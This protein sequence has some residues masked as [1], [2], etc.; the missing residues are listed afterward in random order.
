M[1][2]PGSAPPRGWP[3][4]EGCSSGASSLAQRLARGQGE[5][6]AALLAETRFMLAQALWE[7]PPHRGRDRA[8]ATRLAEQARD[9]LA[10]HGAARAED[11]AE[12]ER[13]L[14]EHV[15]P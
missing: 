2:K 14:R 11:V 1:T 7:A 15:E 4:R 10:E 12:I 6:P 9:A 8:R 5:S 13:W 3:D